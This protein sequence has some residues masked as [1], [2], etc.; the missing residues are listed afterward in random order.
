MTIKYP[1]SCDTWN[2]QEIGAINRVMRNGRYT[3][4]PEVVKFEE[5]F[6]GYMG[7]NHARMVN[8]GSSANLLMIASAIF[9]PEYD[10]KAGDKVIVP[11]VSWSTT[12]YP[13]QQYGLEL[14]FVDVDLYT[15]NLCPTKTAQALEEIE[16][17]KAILT[18]NLLGNP[19]QIDELKDLADNYSILLFEDNCESFGSSFEGKMMGTYGS[20]GTHSFF[21]SHHLQTMEG[22]M[23]LTNS[24]ETAQ[25][26]D[27]LRAHGWLRTLPDKNFIHDKTGDPFE[28][29][30][31]FVLPGYSV[32]P[33]EMSGAIG[34]VQLAKWPE[35]MKQRVKNAEYFKWKFGTLPIIIQ[36]EIGVS[37][38]FGFSCIVPHIIGRKKFTDALQEGGV[39][40]RPIVAGNFL[41][42]PVMKHIDHQISGTMENADTIHDQGFFLGN[43]SEDIREKIDHAYNIINAVILD[44]GME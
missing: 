1:L 6:A 22:G 20:M 16:G 24:E 26:I 5:E 28:D 29:S 35:M 42:N 7:V 12:Y 44:G 32:R 43:D 36:K 23:I 11:S 27:S 33:L 13:L 9:S 2:N 18:V 8:S 19:S 38:W 17:I 40:I 39:E 4:G 37:S 15:L 41:R 31:R 21:F 14:V 34:Q 25:Y 3:M 10:L 30:F